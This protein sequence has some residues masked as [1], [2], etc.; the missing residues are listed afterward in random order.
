MLQSVV[1]FTQRAVDAA[2][3]VV[4]AKAARVA[5]EVVLER[6]A[7]AEADRIAAE[8]EG[9]AARDEADRAHIRARILAS[10]AKGDVE[11][12]TFVEVFGGRRDRLQRVLAQLLV[13]GAIVTYRMDRRVYLHAANIEQRVERD[14]AA[15]WDLA[16]A[17]GVTASAKDQADQERDNA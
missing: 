14:E 3:D 9:Q 1:R 13:E 12:A 15:S 16:E 11:R 5:V 6:Q 10:L 8:V 7:R 17:A 4:A 2:I